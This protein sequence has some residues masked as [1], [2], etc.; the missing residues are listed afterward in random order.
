MIRLF[1]LVLFLA[2]SPIPSNAQ[3]KTISVDLKR[4]KLW[5]QF[6]Q[7]L[8]KFHQQRIATLDT[9][10]ETS[11]GGYG[12]TTNDLNF[13]RQDK[14]FDKHTGQLLADIKWENKNPENLHAID[15]YVHDAQGRI[16]KEYIAAYLPVHRKAPI[17]TLINLH[18]YDD[19]LHS[20][21]QFDVSDN[22]IFEFCEGMYAGEKVHI[23][24]D[25]YEI[26]DAAEDL[27]DEQMAKTYRACFDEVPNSV[28]LYL[29]PMM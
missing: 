15:I 8:Y 1:G 5:N 16:E 28:K 7:D 2:F 23:V 13:Y 24:L 3:E 19:S 20:F 14:Y 18:V 27:P 25:E 9:R 21:R 10:I 12:G 6:V 26:P 17:Q 22:L 11:N 4:T 29:K